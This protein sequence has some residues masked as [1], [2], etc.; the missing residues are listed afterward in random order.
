MQ[1][2]LGDYRFKTKKEARDFIRTIREKYSYGEFINEKDFNI[3][4]EAIKTWSEEDRPKI[5][6]IVEIKV[7]KVLTGKPHKNFQ[8]C[9]KGGSIKS[10]A[11]NKCF[12][13]KNSK[14]NEQK[15]KLNEASRAAIA[16]QVIQFKQTQKLHNGKFW[17]AAENRE[18]DENEKLHVDHE[19]PCFKK[20]VDVFIAT[21]GIKVDKVAF[22][23]QKYKPSRFKDKSLEA[24]WQKYHKKHAKLQILCAKCNLSKRCCC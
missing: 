10:F 11:I 20:L 22:E 13:P 6:D 3:I 5:E 2:Q 7:I 14:V 15:E 21:E 17:C 1:V 9:L 12:P 8:I 19:E 16:D 4:T 24:K 18:I 23:K